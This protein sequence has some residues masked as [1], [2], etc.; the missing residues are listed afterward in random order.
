HQSLQSIDLHKVH[1]II[2]LLFFDLLVFEQVLDANPVHV[3]ALYRRGM[4]YMLGGDF[5]DA[6][7][8]FE[9]MVTVDKSSEPDATAAL[10]KLKQKEQEIEK[11]AR[12]QFKGLFDKKPGEIS[13]VGMESKNGGDTAGSGEAVTSRDRDGSGK[14][15]PPSAESDHAFDEEKPGLI[16][17]IWPSARR[18]FSSL[19]LNRCT[20]L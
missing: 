11:K 2:L 10:V 17:R 4:S 19:G 16:G 18:I 7:N 8:D 5:D 3:K 14:S 1:I 20:I 9:K 12:K 13:E 15:S 6:K